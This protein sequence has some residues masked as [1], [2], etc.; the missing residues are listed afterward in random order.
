MLETELPLGNVSFETDNDDG[1][2]GDGRISIERFVM[3][4]SC[5]HRL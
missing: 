5:I 1:C 4:M 2:D 3:F